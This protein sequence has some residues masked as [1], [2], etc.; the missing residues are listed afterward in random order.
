MTIK[1]AML[2]SGE[3]VI[4]D[5]QEMVVGDVDDEKNQK[6][7][8]YFFTKPCVVRLTNPENVVDK[9]GNKSY[10]ISL[11]P[12]N[13]LSKDLKIP[14]STD[15]VITMVEPVEKLKSMYEEVLNYGKG[16]SQN[17]STIEQSDSNN[18]D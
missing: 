11:S 1:L 13:P 17:T 5:I 9:E 4:A 15:W 7:I 16:T 6:V 18:S 8:G 3:D 2:K 14:V 10:E 12:W